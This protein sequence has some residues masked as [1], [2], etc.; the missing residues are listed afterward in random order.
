MKRAELKAGE[1][2]A[3]RESEEYGS[4]A[5]VRV[6][7]TEPVKRY[8]RGGSVWSESRAMSANK[9]G[10]RIVL[11]RGS[12]TSVRVGFVSMEKL[13][14]VLESK[15]PYAI[16][17]VEEMRDGVAENG[18]QILRALPRFIRRTWADHEAA[19]KAAAEVKERQAIRTASKKEWLA[20]RISR[21]P[22]ELQE[23]IEVSP[24]NAQL[25]ELRYWDVEKLVAILIDDDSDFEEDEG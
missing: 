8:V 1:V 25:K 11:E 13:T 4:F 23:I 5:K 2:Y 20:E 19:Q 14:A 22:E 17:R 16:K 9:D 7:D 12:P 18:N 10:V 24:H 3:Y 21:L 6:I 15:N